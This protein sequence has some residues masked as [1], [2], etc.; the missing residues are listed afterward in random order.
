[1]DGGVQ[2][3]GWRTQ[4]EVKARLMT[5]FKAAFSCINGELTHVL[6]V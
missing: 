5:E 4:G 1:M 6:Y 3:H 2:V